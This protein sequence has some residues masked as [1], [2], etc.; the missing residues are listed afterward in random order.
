MGL[1]GRY[2]ISGG[3]QCKARGDAQWI[4]EF[5]WKDLHVSKLEMLK[6]TQVGLR[7]QE[8]L[9]CR[10]CHSRW[11][12]EKAIHSVHRE[13]HLVTKGTTV[14][15]DTLRR[16]IDQRSF[17]NELSQPDGLRV[18]CPGGRPTDQVVLQQL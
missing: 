4:D 10:R 6:S 2:K 13:D 14:W 9:E 8:L 12:G 3:A 15:L 7:V 17:G 1:L 16:L 11:P 5:Q 18:V